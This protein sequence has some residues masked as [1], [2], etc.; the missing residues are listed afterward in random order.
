MLS[1]YRSELMGWAIL[2]I[3][4]LHFGFHSVTPLGFVSQYGFAGVEI[5]LFVSGLGIYCSLDRDSRLPSFYRKRAL[6]IFPAY[7]FLCIFASLLVYGD[8]IMTWLYRCTTIGFWTGGTI[9]FGWYVPSIVVLYL[10][11]PLLKKAIDMRLH[12]VMAVGVVA[13]LVVSYFLAKHQTLNRE[14]FFFVYRIPAFIFGMYCAMF[15]KHG[16]AAVPDADGSA[17]VHDANGRGDIL[18]LVLLLAGIPLFAVFYPLHHTVY[19]FKYYSLLYLL[20]LFMY[21]FCLLTRLLGFARP[22]L[23]AVGTASLEIYLIQNIF[24]SA[25]IDG[26]IVIPERWHDV[27]S[28]GLMTLC[29]LAGIIIHGTI[30]KIRTR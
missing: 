10:V 17:A 9:Y 26:L 28:V 11:A 25:I 15:I 4:M 5:F 30:Q 2:W 7:C 24:F 6:R 23:R 8:D 1:T 14:H 18:Y 12:A 20:P 19:E 27:C 22:L 16:S 3:M 13:I 21:L 29:S